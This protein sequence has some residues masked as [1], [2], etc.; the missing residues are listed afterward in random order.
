MSIDNEAQII[1][2]AIRGDGKALET[3]VD[4]YAPM[5]YKFAYSV[6]RNQDKAEHTTQETFLSMIRKLEQFDGRSKLSTWLYTI[7]SNHCMMLARSNKSDRQVSL[8]SDDFT[9]TESAVAQW[10]D[11]PL[12]LLERGDTRAHI[13]DAIA[14]LPAEYRIVFILRDIQELSTEEVAAVTGLSIPAVKSR[15]HRA[16]AFLRT[17]LTPLFS[18]RP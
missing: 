17:A 13:D 18:E 15:L 7:V 3:L 4:E 11:N 5:I 10:S 9:L 14:K 6:C 8:D 2:K 12:E 1:E 16:R